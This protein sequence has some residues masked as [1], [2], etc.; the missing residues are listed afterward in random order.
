MKPHCR[1]TPPL[2]PDALRWVMLSYC[3]MLYLRM[4]LEIEAEEP[5]V[6][7]LPPAELLSIANE[8]GK[9]LPAEQPKNCCTEISFPLSEQHV[10]QLNQWRVWFEDQ[11]ADKLRRTDE[12]SISGTIVA[13]K[14]EAA[15]RHMSY[16]RTRLNQ[17]IG[18]PSPP[19]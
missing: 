15:Y 8:L 12:Q 11:L 9:R 10:Y 2:Q 7:P 19:E 1:P 16:L 13:A 6:A 18:P 5:H 14:I 4:M 17:R 3:H